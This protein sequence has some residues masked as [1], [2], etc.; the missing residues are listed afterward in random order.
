MALASSCGD[1]GAP[2]EHNNADTRTDPTLASLAVWAWGSLFPSLIFK[3]ICSAGKT[4]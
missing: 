2:A 4:S 3:L 1:Q